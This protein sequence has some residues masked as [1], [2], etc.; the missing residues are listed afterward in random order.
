MNFIQKIPVYVFSLLYPIKVYGKE[1]IPQGGAVF[2]CNHFRA[3]DCGFIA[4]ISSKKTK[5]LAKKEIFK[6]TYHFNNSH[7][8]I[9]GSFS[10]YI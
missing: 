3:I 6:N 1:N 2:S 4:L 9:S 5:Y 10:Y 7:N 8:I